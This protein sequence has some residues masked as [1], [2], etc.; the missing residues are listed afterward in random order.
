MLWS[1][2]QTKRSKGPYIKGLLFFC[3]NRGVWYNAHSIGILEQRKIGMAK[4]YTVI[5]GVNGAGKSSL[6]GVLK[7]ERDDLGMIIDIDKMASLNGWAPIQAG[8]QALALMEN[9]CERGISFTQETTLSSHQVGKMV[10][11]VKEHGYE[12]HLFYVGISSA[13]ECLKR[14][15]NRVGKGGHDIRE[16][17]VRRRFARRFDVLIDILPYCN[18]AKFYD[19]EN[20]F[21]MIAE[22]QNGDFMRT[23]GEMPGWFFEMEKK[24]DAAR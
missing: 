17:D 12:V 7:K 24:Y 3:T 19:N 23:S 5:G 4:V 14:I 16:E 6:T 8:K 13:E 1:M 11:K 21:E 18:E 9:Y 20:G 22:Y 2:F 10:R 15:A